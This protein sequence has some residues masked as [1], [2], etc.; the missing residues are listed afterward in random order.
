MDKGEYEKAM[1]KF[2]QSIKEIKSQMKRFP[3]RDDIFQTLVALDDG[4]R[5]L[6]FNCDRFAGSSQLQQIRQP[7]W[8]SK[9]NHKR[10]LLMEW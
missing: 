5:F 8:Q 2:Y 9:K 7:R 6:I 4:V 1:E 3:D 10:L